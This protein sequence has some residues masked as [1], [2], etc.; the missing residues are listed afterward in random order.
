MQTDGR[1]RNSGYYFLGLLGLAIIG[2]WNSYFSQLFTETGRYTHFHA[3]TMLLWLA[4]LI[5][6]PFLV[7]YQKLDL[8]R[9][10][11]RL[12]YVLFPLLVVSVILLAHS[13][14]IIYE[15]GIRASRRYILFLQLGLLLIFC[16]NYVLA[17]RY[18]HSLAHH[19]RFMIGTALTLIDPAVAR[20][21]I[22]LPDLPVKY[23]V[24]TFSAVFLV[25]V[26]L[27]VLER[28]QKRAQLVF[29]FILAMFAL[30]L[31][32]LV[33]GTNSMAWQAFSLWFANLPLT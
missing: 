27:I 9:R 15:D 5:S 25:L 11:G 7:R 18:R 31:T 29:P 1:F 10:L 24:V 13:Q 28:Q 14:I 33:N 6:Q 8:H 26:V 16:I 4:L 21:P 30:C 32:L 3:I 23:Q 22:D 17:I 20:L 2:F 19:A 12:S